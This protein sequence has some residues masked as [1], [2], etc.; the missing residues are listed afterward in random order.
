M[1]AGGRADLNWEGIPIVVCPGR[2]RVA[3]ATLFRSEAKTLLERIQNRA[4][5]SPEEKGQILEELAESRDIKVA[6][7]FGIPPGITAIVVNVT[8]ANTDNGGYLTVWP[9]GLPQPPSSNLNWDPGRNTPN[10][11]IVGV[12]PDGY[13][14]IFNAVGGNATVIVDV[15]G[16]VT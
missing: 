4:W 11:V 5:T 8:A 12:S 14:S 15:F 16:Y 6:G 13:I 9:K 10:M 2:S 7:V 1:P 3:L